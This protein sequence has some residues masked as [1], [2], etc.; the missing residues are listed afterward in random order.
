MKI[1]F[2]IIIRVYTFI[3]DFVFALSKKEKKSIFDPEYDVISIIQTVIIILLTLTLVMFVYSV[4][5]GPDE[6]ITR[7]AID[8]AITN[9]NKH[10]ST[11]DAKEKNKDIE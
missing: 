9:N 2:L 10:I 3:I 5:V 6:P 8:K 7:Q 4:E 1:I 11:K